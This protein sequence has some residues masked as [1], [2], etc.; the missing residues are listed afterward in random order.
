MKYFLFLAAMIMLF[1]GCDSKDEPIMRS[2]LEVPEKKDPEIKD[3]MPAFSKGDPAKI[4]TTASGLQYEVIEEGTGTSPK[5]GQD[6]T[7]HYAGWLMDGTLFDASYQRGAPSTFQ[8]GRV[9]PGW[10]EGL[11]LMKEGA[12]YRFIIPAELGYG[13]RGSPPTIPP[14]ATLVFHVKLIKVGK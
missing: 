4:K 8:L 1:A 5:M 6:V 2:P 12:T 10:K 11:Q 9:I 14:D 7:C 3:S 13:K